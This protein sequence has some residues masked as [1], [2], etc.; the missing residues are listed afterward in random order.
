MQKAVNIPQSSTSTFVMRSWMVSPEKCHANELSAP[1]RVIG[2]G[3]GNKENLADA[4]WKSEL[5]FSVKQT[6][7]VT[8]LSGLGVASDS[9]SDK[10]RNWRNSDAT[11]QHGRGFCGRSFRQHLRRRGRRECTHVIAV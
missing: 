10:H 6:M 9:G 7:P 11:G 1:L 2:E 3:R 8:H 4:A 5:S